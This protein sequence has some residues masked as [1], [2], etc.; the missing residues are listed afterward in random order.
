MAKFREA[1]HHAGEASAHSDIAD[2]VRDLK[3]LLAELGRRRPLRD[4]ISAIDPEL[5]P[6]QVHTVLWLGSDGAM[7]SNVL[8]QRLGCGQPTVT[9]LIDRL[10]TLG[11]CERERSTDDRRVVMAKLTAKGRELHTEL[12]KRVTE[13]LTHVLGLLSQTDR[14]HLLRIIKHLV[15][16]LHDKAHGTE[17]SS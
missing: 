16:A 2:H 13:K 15:N 17:K 10:E 8:S 11:Y 9:G 6:P 14:G 12:E 3:T 1:K 7:A 5:T 4:P